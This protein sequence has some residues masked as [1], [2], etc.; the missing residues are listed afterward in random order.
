M[1]IQSIRK[2]IFPA[3]S[4]AINELEQSNQKV[5]LTILRDIFN[6]AINGALNISHTNNSSIKS[7]FSGR[8]RAW[9]KISADED[10]PVW[11]KIKEV[12]TTEMTIADTNSEMFSLSSNMLDLFE[13]SGIAWIRFGSSSK[14]YT[15]FHLRLWGSKLD[16]HIKIYIDNHYVNDKFIQNLEGVP[17]NLGLESGLLRNDINIKEKIEK[18]VS[19]DEL[20]MLG[21]ISIDDILI[22]ENNI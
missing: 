7:I 11:V 18:E 21:I 13:N 22:D 20:D 10:N 17:H 19:K 4:S 5:K 12:L 15:K 3:V 1:D 14:G 8:G 2:I 6:E 9:A 16:K